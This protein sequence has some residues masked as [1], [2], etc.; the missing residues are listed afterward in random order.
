MIRQKR[1]ISIIL[2]ITLVF[3]FAKSEE[4][5]RA[6]E[7]TIVEGSQLIIDSQNAQ[8]SVAQVSEITGVK[9]RLHEEELAVGAQKV[10]LE[11][12]EPKEVEQF[13]S[14]LRND[15]KVHFV[16]V[17]R[18]LR[19]MLGKQYSPQWNISNH[20]FLEAWKINKGGGATIAVLDTGI[21]PH[22]ALNG[23][24][25]PGA[26]LISDPVAAK[27][28]DGRDMDPTDEGDSAEAGMC[29]APATPSTFHGTGIAGAIVGNEDNPF[30]IV[31]AAPDASVVPV[32][33][34]GVCG[35]R[36]S[37]LTDAIMWAAGKD[38]KGVSQNRSPVTIIN[39]SLAIRDKCSVV[40][41]KAITYARSNEVN[42][43]TATGNYN[44]NSDNFSPGNCEG[45]FNVGSVNSVG[46]LTEHSN[47][48]ASTDIVGPGG[49]EENGLAIPAVEG[50]NKPIDFS[51]RYRYGTSL[52]A[53]HVSAGLGIVG[54]IFP[55]ASAK[56]REDFL[57]KVGLKQAGNAAQGYYPVFS[58]ENIGEHT[59]SPSSSSF[60]GSSS[61]PD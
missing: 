31:G 54:Q 1:T 33:V 39:V 18:I 38:V 28:G 7:E 34:S 13:I 20:G 4:T 36:V 10:S 57:L 24:L 50:E 2:A 16:E 3:L 47:Y 53:A 55:S 26:D 45:A 44:A 27:D 30:G 19:P 14:L 42:V 43:V 25:L 15:I 46:M 23:K 56:Q 37:D 9:A 6:Q 35:A 29:A 51:Y 11:T 22:P 41:Q 58:L 59:L 48:G 60:E 32:R 8:E 12:S 17:D 49:D 21:L 61:L 40:M 52:A 5:I